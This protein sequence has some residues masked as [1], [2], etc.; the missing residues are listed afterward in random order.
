[1]VPPER[2]RRPGPGNPEVE[3]PRVSVSSKKPCP[4]AVTVFVQSPPNS[5]S[6]LPRSS[7][8]MVVTVCVAASRNP[9][10]KK[11]LKLSTFQPKGNCS[12]LRLFRMS[13]PTVAFSVICWLGRIVT[14]PL[15]P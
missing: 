4:P 1:M 6:Q 8:V 15:A 3:P 13:A 5:V 2:E 11:G 9:A 7:P 12:W 10:T 14:F